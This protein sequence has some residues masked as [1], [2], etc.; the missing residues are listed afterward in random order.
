M[1]HIYKESQFWQ[2]LKSGR[3]VSMV[4]E[5]AKG[6]S[7]A[8]A[9]EVYNIMKPIFAK[10]NDVEK[11]YIIFL[12]AKNKILCIENIFSGSINSAMIYNREVVKKILEQRANA[13]ILVHN[14]PSGDPNPS[15][16]DR[17]MTVKVGFAAASID[18]TL[19]DH[20]IVG[21]GFY[22]F[23]DKGLI[24]NVSRKFSELMNQTPMTE[25]P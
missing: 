4:K 2:D 5:T 17:E 7:I 25:N 19:H 8:N 10:E 9:G 1:N 18:V 22:S 24:T 16:E 14:H 21:D 6:Q 15:P 11:V 23:A 13:I 20:V 12:N 3:F